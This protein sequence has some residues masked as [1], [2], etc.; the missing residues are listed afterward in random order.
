MFLG[1]WGL[2]ARWLRGCLCCDKGID[3][4]VYVL[5]MDGGWWMEDDKEFYTPSAIQL[6]L[7]LGKRRAEDCE[8]GWDAIGERG[9]VINCTQKRNE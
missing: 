4:V 5:W 7:D 2:L 8:R 9:A 6:C 3:E 1:R